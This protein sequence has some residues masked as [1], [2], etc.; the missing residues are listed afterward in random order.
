MNTLT[1]MQ[2]CLVAHLT[3][4]TLMAGTTVTEYII[5]KT[6]GKMPDIGKEKALNLLQLT[7][8]LSALLGVGAALLILSG[9]GLLIITHGAFMH[10]LW[11]K[12]KLM[13]IAALVLN[14]FLTGSRLELKFKRTINADEPVSSDQL[15]KAISKFNTFYSVQM[16]LFF[17]III[18]AIFKFN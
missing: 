13:L 16:I 12:I 6:F 7:K 2:I 8:K 5:F 4:L 3:G 10:Q 17:T 1:L 14:G 18:L 11:L 9:T 15:K